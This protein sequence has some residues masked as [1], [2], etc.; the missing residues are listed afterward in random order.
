LRLA[1]VNLERAKGLFEKRIVPRSEYDTALAAF[2]EARAQVANLQAI[3]SKKII[4]APFAGKVGIRRVNLGQT[5]KPGEELIPLHQSDPIF[6]EFAVPQ[7]RL[8][9]VKIGQTLRLT[10]D[11]L[12]TPVT[13]RVE[14]INPVIDEVTRTALVQGIL[15]N[16]EDRLR[17]GQFAIVDVILPGEEDVVAI[18]ASAVLAEAYGT[19]VFI[20]D[21]SGSQPVVR[22]QFVQ[23]GARKGDFVQVLKG[24]EPGDRVVS[25]GAFKLTNGARVEI[26]DAMQPEPSLNPNP[27]NA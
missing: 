23:L 1:Q 14:A 26:H 3:I 22:Q 20:V 27:P 19:S 25:A 16:P 18:P 4:R 7:T 13:G 2:D 5:V 6:V 8:A 21:E 10:T 12:D 24:L 15:R 11:G 9:S 17:A